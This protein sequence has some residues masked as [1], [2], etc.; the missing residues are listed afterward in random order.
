VAAVGPVLDDHLADVR[1]VDVAGLVAL[2][3]RPA[4][5]CSLGQDPSH[6]PADASADLALRVH[7]ALA[8]PLL[9]LHLQAVAVAPGLVKPA[10]GGGHLDPERREAE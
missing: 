1:L 3:G 9:R 5:T 6:H 2:A 4:R 7:A 8:L 10:V